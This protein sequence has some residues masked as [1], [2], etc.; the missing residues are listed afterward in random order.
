MQRLARA[1]LVLAQIFF[2]VVVWLGSDAL[3][4]A[5]G[6]SLPGSVIGLSLVCLLLFSGIL[7]SRH[8][9]RGADWLLAEMLLFFIPPVV[10]VVNFG[11]LI[12]SQGWRLLLVLLLGMLVVM[13]GTGLVVDWVFRFECRRHAKREGKAP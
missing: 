5:A 3:A 10:A 2:F 9:Q 7:P 4:R 11:P 12:V 8:V 6:W 1:G 13:V